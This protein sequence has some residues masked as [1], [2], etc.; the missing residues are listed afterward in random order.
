MIIL[1]R[2]RYGYCELN[3]ISSVVGGIVAQEAVKVWEKYI[4]I[5]FI[6][7]INIYNRY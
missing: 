6:I 7:N 5:F 3:S 1:L 2:I 4:H